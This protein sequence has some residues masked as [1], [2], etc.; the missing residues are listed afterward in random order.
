MNRPPKEGPAKPQTRSALARSAGKCCRSLMP[1]SSAARINAEERGTRGLA[2]GNEIV[3]NVH[4]ERDWR[5]DFQRMD[6]FDLA[7]IASAAAR[8][9]TAVGGTI[10]FGVDNLDAAGPERKAPNV[11]LGDEALNKWAD[12]ALRFEFEGD[13]HFFE[14]WREAMGFEMGSDEVEKFF[15]ARAQLNHSAASK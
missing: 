11:T 3:G 2:K 7:K 10:I 9:A 5:L 4:Q 13:A 6:E 15:L 14:R 1:D 12:I 8:V